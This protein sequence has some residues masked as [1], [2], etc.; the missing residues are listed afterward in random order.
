MS[1]AALHAN[2]F[3]EDAAK[4]RAV[5]T[6]LKDD[7]F[8]VFRIDAAE[9]IPFWSTRSRVEKVRE[10]HPKYGGHTIEEI[11]LPDFLAKTLPLLAEEGLR[12][13]VNWSGARLT[14]YDISVDDVR[15]IFSHHVG[16][17]G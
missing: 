13:G 6:F 11:S 9:V 16:H 15:R 1:T 17:E 8:L 14:G 10:L 7:S 3:Y 12:V 5:F 4:K 2:A